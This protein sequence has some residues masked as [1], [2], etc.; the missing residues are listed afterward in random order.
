M[1][2]VHAFTLKSEKMVSYP[3]KLVTSPCNYHRAVG[4]ESPGPLQEQ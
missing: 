4:N 3:L 2:H 1:H